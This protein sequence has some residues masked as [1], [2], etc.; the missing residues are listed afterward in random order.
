MNQP[1]LQAR[2]FFIKACCF[3]A[4]LIL[5]A[6]VL[7]WMAGIDPFAKLFYSEAALLYGILGTLPMVLF[8]HWAERRQED[9]FQ[10][11]R[12][13]LLETLGPSLYRRHWADLFMLAAIA[14]LSEEILF[15]G[16]VQ[17]WLEAAWGMRAALLGCNILFGLA[18]AVTP[19]YTLLAFLIGLY[20]S[21]AMDYGGTRNLLTPVLIHALYDFWA[22]AA[23]VRAYK[24]E[25]DGA[26]V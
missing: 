18:H 14:G 21:G 8:F 20:L 11:V 26:G 9:S 7:G 22:F 23:L 13:L 2:D 10:K 15:R 6:I 12:R 16:V 5:V 17:P 4:S 25:R 24:R 1:P 19:L 3:E